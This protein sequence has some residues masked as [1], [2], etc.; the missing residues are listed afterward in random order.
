MSIDHTLSNA[1]G[2]FSLTLAKKALLHQNTTNYSASPSCIFMVLA[3]V[4]VGSKSTSG[5]ELTKQLG[6]DFS[7]IFTSG[8]FEKHRLSLAMNELFKKMNERSEIYS[9]IFSRMALNDKYAH[10]L[11]TVFKSTIE[12]IDFHNKKESVAKINSWVSDCTNNRINDILTESQIHDNIAFV[13]INIIFFKSE[14]KN[15][16]NSKDSIWVGGESR[17]HDTKMHCAF[18]R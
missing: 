18:V 15:K 8:E 13:L 7:S 2:E 17:V 14:W 9:K 5:D 11:E 6:V 4:H 12:A 3:M 10:V 1:I 16:F